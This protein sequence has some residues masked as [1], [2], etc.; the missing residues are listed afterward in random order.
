[1]TT[2]PARRANELLQERLC[3][4][5]KF[6]GAKA[7]G[8][9][10]C[11]ANAGATDGNSVTI[12]DGIN[13]PVTYE[14]DKSSNGVAAGN[15]TWAVGTTAASLATALAALIATNQPALTVV[16]DLAGNLTITT[17][18][19]NQ[20]LGTITKSGAGAV[21]AVTGY[22][23]A[24]TTDK[25]WKAKAR[26][27]RV[28]RVFLNLPAGMAAHASNYIVVK[29]LKGATVMASWS[30][31]TGADGTITADTPV[32]LTLSATD[33]NRVLADADI[34]S[35]SVAVTGSPTVPKGR[36]VIEGRYL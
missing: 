21:T 25:V 9:I 7:T 4:E 30:T 33:A 18:F 28:D 35:V 2:S 8:T 13:P 3:L 1:M 6:E 15:V 24:T 27:F 19:A 17:P 23:A 5:Y 22:T 34:M 26:Y 10:A 36:I 20:F 16:D 14:Y 32:D 12:G 11:G 29:V 31:L